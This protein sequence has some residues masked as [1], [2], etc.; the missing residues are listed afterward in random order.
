[1]RAIVNGVS[2]ILVESE[3]WR[4][5]FPNG[6]TFALRAFLKNMPRAAWLQ[7][8]SKCLTI[9]ET[10]PP[11]VTSKSGSSRIPA[12]VESE[13]WRDSFPNGQTFAL[14]TSLKNMQ[15]AAWLQDESKCLT[16]WESIPP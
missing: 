5:S 16:V 12:L 13:T 2:Q 14:R 11:C 8:E 9:W 4:D 1:M 6:Q 10:I 3:T 15:R 7:D